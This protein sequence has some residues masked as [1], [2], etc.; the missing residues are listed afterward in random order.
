MTS[1]E[2]IS[3]TEDLTQT[4]GGDTRVDLRGEIERFRNRKV[5]KS[6]VLPREQGQ[7]GGGRV[8]GEQMSEI[9]TR[10]VTRKE[11]EDCFVCSD[12][13]KV[14]GPS[15]DFK[16]SQFTFICLYSCVVISLYA[17][18]KNPNPQLNTQNLRL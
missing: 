14:D 1:L 10:A 18:D 4:E 6:E 7:G 9:R 5:R 3:R 16:E 13:I 12:V 8:N 15:A 17:C 2:L 11:E